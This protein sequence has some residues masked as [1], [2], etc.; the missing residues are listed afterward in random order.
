MKPHTNH[1]QIS[2]LEQGPC[3]LLLMMG[4]AHAHEGYYNP[5]PTCNL[6][7]QSRQLLTKNIFYDQVNSWTNYVGYNHR[8]NS[9]G[10]QKPMEL[11]EGSMLP[12]ES[13]YQLALVCAIYLDIS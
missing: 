11:Q 12:M 7:G 10:H 8:F 6:M 4:E 1:I 2:F 9:T 13:W 3:S 5:T